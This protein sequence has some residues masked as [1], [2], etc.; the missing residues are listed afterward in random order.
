M[1]GEKLSAYLDRAIAP[2]TI[3]NICNA[4]GLSS[5]G[6]FE[7]QPA[8]SAIVAHLKSASEKWDAEKSDSIRRRQK[9]EA[10]EAEMRSLEAMGKLCPME[11]AK[12]FIADSIIEFKQT[13]ERA[14]YLTPVQ[15][16]RL[17]T[18]VSALKPKLDR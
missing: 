7:M 12:L 10:D 16:T 4:E 3:Q 1:S 8:M 18:E 17:L 2:R 5:R 11:T 13:I 9:A 14:Q 15:R 6:G